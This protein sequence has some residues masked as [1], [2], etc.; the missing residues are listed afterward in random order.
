MCQRWMLV[1]LCCADKTLRKNKRTAPRM[2]PIVKELPA[3]TPAK[4]QMPLPCNAEK[5]TPIN[6]TNRTPLADRT[7]QL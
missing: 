4:K 2:R 1:W 3:P 7:N 6:T 5:K